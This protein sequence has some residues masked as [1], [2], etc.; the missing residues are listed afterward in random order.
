MKT[1]LRIVSVLLAGL[2]LFSCSSPAPA[3]TTTAA[4]T[5]ASTTVDDSQSNEP[6]NTGITLSYDPKSGDTTE[7]SG[8]TE[9]SLSVKNAYAVGDKIKITLPEGQ[10]YVAFCLSKGNMEETILYL[11]KSTFTY[12][13][14]NIG[15]SY[16]P[17]M[18]SSKKS[19]ITARIPTVEELT[20][21]R[22]LACNPADLEK[23]KNAYPHAITTNVHDKNNESNRLQF[24][25]R[26]A[27]DGF[28]QNKGHGGWPV[29]SWG[30][31]NNMSAKD[32]F[33]LDFGRDVSITK[34][35]IYIRA[36][37]PHDTYWDSCTVKF[38]DGTTQELSFKQ[39]ANAQEFEFD[40]AK[41]VSSITFT[42][43]SK[44]TV[45]GSSNEWAAWMELQVFGSDIIG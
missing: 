9:V 26:N 23:N 36:D 7:E 35:V 29:Q 25:A 12:T 5:T 19:T 27:I 16:P 8:E 44:G 3:E 43:F 32:T 41:V 40:T 39:T 42:N 13:V 28:T 21:S 38:S 24:E 20:A 45:S 2:M 11:P 33:K 31:G 18:K 1:T 34:I 17:A 10:H 4:T 6:T 30:P 37:F 14:Q 15:T 22:N